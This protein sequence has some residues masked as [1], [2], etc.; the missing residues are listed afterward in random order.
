MALRKKKAQVE[1]EMSN[2]GEVTSACAVVSTSQTATLQRHYDDS[3]TPSLRSLCSL[4]LHPSS[5]CAPAFVSFFFFCLYFL[6]LLTLVFQ[7]PRA[8]PRPRCPPVPRPR[9]SSTP[10]LLHAAS[11]VHPGLYWPCRC[12]R[13]CAHL[14]V[15]KFFFLFIVLP[16]LTPI[17]EHASA[18]PFPHA[19]SPSPPTHAASAPSP[20]P[21][22][23]TC[24]ASCA[25]LRVCSRLCLYVLGLDCICNAI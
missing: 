19:V 25:S 23:Y 4:C 24:L 21:P 1:R 8:P 5:V 16:L 2:L 17:S 9:V 6:A 12:P 11:S 14:S 15:R 13:H 10:H 3:S 7:A 22:S 18:V 20:C